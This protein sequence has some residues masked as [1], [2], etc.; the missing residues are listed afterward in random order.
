MPLHLAFSPGWTKK[1]CGC[2][3]QRSAP[4]WS[5]HAAA[6]ADA[7]RRD[8]QRMRLRPWRLRCAWLASSAWSAWPSHVCHLAHA[9]LPHAHM[10]H[11]AEGDKKKRGAC[12]LL[13]SMRLSL[14][15]WGLPPGGGPPTLLSLDQHSGGGGA[16]PKCLTLGIAQA[17]RLG[18][19]SHLTSTLAEAGLRPS[20]SRSA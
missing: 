6:I 20:A 18:L 11:E 9:P 2:D 17:W 5:T 15:S 7:A 4:Q 3:S 8:G 19:C 16:P 13:R 12:S 14:V 10:P 1:A